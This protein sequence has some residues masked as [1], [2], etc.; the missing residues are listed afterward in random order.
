MLI[1][2]PMFAKLIDTDNEKALELLILCDTD[3]EF[4]RYWKFLNRPACEYSYMNEELV[5]TSLQGLTRIVCSLQCRVEDWDAAILV[6]YEAH[7]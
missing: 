7:F 6:D 5:F 2:C 4:S 1:D 3:E